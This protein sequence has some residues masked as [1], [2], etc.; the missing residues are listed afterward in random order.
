MT[1]ML[2][3]DNWRAIMGYFPWHFWG[4]ASQKVK[5]TSASNSVM[6]QYDWQT[7]DRV[8]RSE[9]SEAIETAETMLTD[10]LHYS[11]MQRYTSATVPWPRD[12][13]PEMWRLWPADATGRRLSVTLPEGYVQ[14]VGVEALT[15]IENVSVVLTD[16]DGDGLKDTFTLITTLPLGT[17]DPDEIAIYFEAGEWLTDVQANW[18]IQPVRVSIAAGVATIKGKSWLLVKPVLYEGVNSQDL[19]P[20]TAA[21]FVVK[22]DVYRRWTDGNGNTNDTSQ[23]LVTWETLPIFAGSFDPTNSTDP[24]A[25]ANAVARCG[26]RNAELGIVTP[27]QAVYDVATG[28]WSNNWCPFPQRPPDRVTVRTLSGMPLVYGQMDR[29]WQTI[30]ARLAAAEMTRVI[31]SNDTGNRE[32]YTWQFDLSRGG[33][34]DVEQFK[35]SEE[36]LSNPFGTRRGHLYAWERVKNLA[37]VRGILA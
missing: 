29:K 24:G 34:R 16:A 35:V 20:D 9:I 18:R 19:D 10:Y 14:K 33:P 22:L 31:T 3:L 32:L 30:V 26:I 12:Y 21:N 23:A 7:A 27:A 5:V 11:P 8:G 4:M 17:T 2:P 15:K 13:Q 37:L 36:D 6:R 25:A 1:H 28:T